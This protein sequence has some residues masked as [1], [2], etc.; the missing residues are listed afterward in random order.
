MSQKEIT[1]TQHKDKGKAHWSRYHDLAQVEEMLSLTEDK[2]LIIDPHPWGLRLQHKA[3]Q[4]MFQGEDA[5]DSWSSLQAASLRR[6]GMGEGS[7]TTLCF[8]FFS[9]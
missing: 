2:E 3:W 9:H 4:L 8:D 7:T 1:T 5:T 6:K